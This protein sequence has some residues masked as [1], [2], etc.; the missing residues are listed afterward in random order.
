MKRDAFTLAPDDV[1]EI[2]H[3]HL[4]C[5]LGGDA[6]AI[7]DF[8]R[9]TGTRPTGWHCKSSP[10]THTRSLLQEM[11]FAYDSNDYGGEVPHILQTAQQQPYVVLPYAFDT[12]D[13]RFFGQGAFVHA[14]DFARYT[15]AAIDT[16]LDEAQ[17][18]PRLL[19]IGLHTRI[20]GRPARIAALDMILRH[21]RR[22]PS[23]IWVG[24]RAHVAK[25]WLS[26]HAEQNPVHA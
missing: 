23:A 10:S 25:H 1:R 18:A 21:I 9:L 5:G 8:E 15:I 3:F 11:G 16:L 7:R 13:M 22:H 4:F 2:R 24:T 17:H 20:L 14:D 12:N 26:E 6:P 19:T